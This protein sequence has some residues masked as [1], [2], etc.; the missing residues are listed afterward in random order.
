MNRTESTTETNC[1]I[2]VPDKSY[3]IYDIKS[4]E[5][6]VQSQTSMASSY[7]TSILEQEYLRKLFSYQ[8][9]AE[10]LI[11]FSGGLATKGLSMGVDTESIPTITD[12]FTK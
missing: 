1:S 3:R 8:I 11:L 7:G 5:W 9:L 12:A 4:T 2:E 6:Q 10:N